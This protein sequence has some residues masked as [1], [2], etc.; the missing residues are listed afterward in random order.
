MNN[1]SKIVKGHN[2]KSHRNQVTKF[3]NV[4]A[5]KTQ[6]VQWKGTVKLITQFRNVT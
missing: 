4:I 5:E 3:Q 6:N 2:K 1:M